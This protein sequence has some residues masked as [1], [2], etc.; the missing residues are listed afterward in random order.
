[1]QKL[2]R[3]NGSIQVVLVQPRGF[4]AGVVR[5]IS[6]V[7]RALEKYDAPVFVRHEI[8]HNKH[9]VDDLKAKGARFVDEIDEIPEGAVTI[10]SAHGVAKDV[11]IS[12]E[13]RGLPVIDA[14][15]PLVTKVHLQGK[16]YLSQGRTLILVGHAGH[17]EV[18][19]T[20]GQI[21]G[22]VHLVQTEDDVAALPVSR[23]TPVAYITQ[24]TLSIDDTRGI[25]LAIKDRF[26][27]VIGPG[28]NDICYATQNRQMAVRELSKIADVILVVG[29]KNSSNSNRLREIGEEAGVPSYLLADGSELKPDWVRGAQ[30]VGLTAGASA[31]EGMVQDVIEA[32]RKLGPV[33]VTNLPGV[34]ENVEF[35]L[36]V[37]LH[38]L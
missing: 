6:I 24:T 9:V 34:E 19:G 10:F 31:P 23:D 17:P 35:R 15:C 14:T 25:I 20:M 13:E 4:C 21:P 28:T 8:V 30:I 16:R 3:A 26:K 18:E 27:D 7:E 38:A 32:L 12:A 33:D 1:M 36:P 5:A 11:E 29:A 37:Q 2:A 22:T